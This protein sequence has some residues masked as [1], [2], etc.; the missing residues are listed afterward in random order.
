MAY[1]STSIRR[2]LRAPL[3]NRLSGLGKPA[4]ARYSRTRA[5]RGLGADPLFPLINPDKVRDFINDVP[6][7]V[8]PALIRQSPAQLLAQAQ[9]V[10]LVPQIQYVSGPSSSSSSSSLIPGVSNWILG[11]GAALLGLVAIASARGRR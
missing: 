8:N 7:A 11:G 4:S 9:A 2:T 3:V 5:L 1:R 6:P 10:G